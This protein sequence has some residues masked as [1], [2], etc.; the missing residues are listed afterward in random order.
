MF[1]TFPSYKIFIYLNNVNLE[2]G[3]F[4]YYPGTHKNILH[5]YKSSILSYLTPNK[6]PLN[7]AKGLGISNIGTPQTG[8]AGAAIFFNVA[9][10]HR[11]GEFNRNIDNE[12]LVL[13][14][15]FR[16]N[17]ALIIPDKLKCNIDG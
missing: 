6:R 4:Q 12:R 9:G 13:L 10:L 2:N 3:A 16:Q 1:F 5:I 14:I 17:D 11:R 7:E 15:D 8:E